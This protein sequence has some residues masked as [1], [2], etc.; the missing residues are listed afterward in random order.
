LAPSSTPGGAQTRAAEAGSE[1]ETE[2]EFEW[3]ALLQ[4]AATNGEWWAQEPRLRKKCAEIVAHYD[5]ERGELHKYDLMKVITDDHYWVR[6][7]GEKGDPEASGRATALRRRRAGL[8]AHLHES[9]TDEH[10]R[11]SVAIRLREI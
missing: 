5:Q 10:S 11:Q 9:P 1:N 8:L 2:E 7:Q 4:I 3:R 6:G